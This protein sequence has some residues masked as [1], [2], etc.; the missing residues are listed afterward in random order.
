MRKIIPRQTY[1]QLRAINGNFHAQVKTGKY[2]HTKNFAQAAAFAYGLLMATENAKQYG[3][4]SIAVAEF[5]VFNGKG[6]RLMI[7]MAERL[8]EKLSINSSSY[9]IIN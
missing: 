4:K 8:L 1:L 3:Y 6:L 2:S 7:S 5:G 9:F